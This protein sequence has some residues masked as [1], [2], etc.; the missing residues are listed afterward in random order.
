MKLDLYSERPVNDG[1]S[2]PKGRGHASSPK[3]R[4][5]RRH[6]EGGRRERSRITS[7]GKSH[8]GMRR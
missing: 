1:A 7:Q 8:P 5:E 4:N 3:N 6:M 2:R